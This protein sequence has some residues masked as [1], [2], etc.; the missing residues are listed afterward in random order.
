MGWAPDGYD[1]RAE[2]CRS[3]TACRGFG[4]CRERNMDRGGWIQTLSGGRFYPADP[5]PEE[6]FIEDIAGALGKLCR[7]GG[8]C[9]RFLSVAEHSVHVA[10]KAHP[11]IRRAALMHDAGEAFLVDMPRPIKSMLPGYKPM[12]NRIMAVAAV[13]F[14]FDWPMPPEVKYLDDAILADERE[15]AM[16]PTSATCEEWGAPHPPLGITLQFWSP[17]EATEQF[18][19]VFRETA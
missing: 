14:G 19:Q 13:R 18:L 15:Q 6:M 5:R 1:C 16:A 2:Q 17:E 12:E 4:Y 3:P 10:R 9:L 8:H 11:A 7:Y